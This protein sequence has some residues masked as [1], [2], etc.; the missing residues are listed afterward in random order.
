VRSPKSCYFLLGPE[1]GEKQTALNG[2]RIKGAEETVYYAGETP[3]GVIVSDLQNGSLFAESR[4]FIIKNS[5]NIKK[6]EDIDLLTS[7]MA[8]PMD[9]TTLVLLSDENS[10]AKGFEKAASTTVKQVFYELS[11]RKKNEWVRDFFEKEGFRVNDEGIDTIL[12]LVENNTEALRQ[13]CSR[14][15]LFLPKDETIGSAEIWKWLSHTRE[16]SAFTLFTRIASGDYS[17]SLECLRTLLAAKVEPQAIL[18]GL[19]WCFRK[20]RDYIALS[21]SGVTDEWEFKKIGVSAPGARRDYSAASRI[22]DS[23]GTETCISLIAEYDHMIRSSSSFPRHIL[24]DE[25]LYKVHFL[26][27]S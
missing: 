19:L 12:E 16:E 25:F 7:Y 3:V 24:M 18:S 8:S 6:K 26:R 13:E 22:Y 17:R 23:F 27:R 15:T 4:L 9:N 14:L 5:E 21:E 2:L 1:L 11:D 10:I 20:L